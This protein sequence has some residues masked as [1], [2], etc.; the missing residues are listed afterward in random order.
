M[1]QAQL[2]LAA[3]HCGA[4]H[5]R[6]EPGVSGGKPGDVAKLKIVLLNKMLLTGRLTQAR[7]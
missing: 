4:D 5:L 7:S 1:L 6:C 3:E 2:T